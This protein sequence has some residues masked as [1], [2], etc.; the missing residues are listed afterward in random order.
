MSHALEA[1]Y[2]WPRGFRPPYTVDVLSELPD[3]GNRYEVLR[4][5]IVVS[6]SAHQA[7]LQLAKKKFA[8]LAALFFVALFGLFISPASAQSQTT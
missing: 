4:G 1:T 5:N 6:P 8:A 2:L 7:F 3:D